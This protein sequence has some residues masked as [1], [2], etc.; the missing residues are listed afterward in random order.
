VLD[1]FQAYFYDLSATMER[2]GTSQNDKARAMKILN[3][4]N[5]I[6]QRLNKKLDRI[7]KEIEEVS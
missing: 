3:E 2:I 1:R 7:R 5:Q 6:S 4:M